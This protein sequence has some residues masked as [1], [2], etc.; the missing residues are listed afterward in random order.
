MAQ[1]AAISAAEALYR[2]QSLCYHR[3]Y[4]AF[5]IATGS[6][7]EDLLEIGFWQEIVDVPPSG[8]IDALHYAHMA[9][10]TLA[11]ARAAG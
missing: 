7:D 8:C 6:G 1:T 11:A 4:T 9:I 10:H 3:G 2:F 5:Q